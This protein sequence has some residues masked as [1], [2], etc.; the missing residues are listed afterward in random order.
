MVVLTSSTTNPLQEAPA[1]DTNVI[2]VSASA[3]Q[4]KPKKKD[5]C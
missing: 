3:G 5:C 1:K 2:N 4:T